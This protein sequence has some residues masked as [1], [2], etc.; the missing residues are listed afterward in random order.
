MGESECRFGLKR[1][2]HPHSRPSNPKVLCYEYAIAGTRYI[3]TI[4]PISWVLVWTKPSL[5]QQSF[6]LSRSLKIPEEETRARL[7]RLLGQHKEEWEN[8]IESL[9]PQS[10][11]TQWV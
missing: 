8:F 4:S 6:W 1:A 7:E 11:V 10:F 2:L 9:G 5:D 3:L